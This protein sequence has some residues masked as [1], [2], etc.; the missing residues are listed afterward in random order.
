MT[1]LGFAI[2]VIRH[3]C[4]DVMIRHVKS[5]TCLVTM[6]VV[7]PWCRF[8]R[9]S[10]LWFIVW[11]IP[12]TRCCLSFDVTAMAGYDIGRKTLV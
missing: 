11:S 7:R 4:I 3:Y 12:W 8:V 2:K 10:K 5:L 9:W 6:L 1:H